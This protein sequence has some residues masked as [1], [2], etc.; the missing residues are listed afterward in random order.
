[1]FKLGNK[2][3]TKLFVWIGEIAENKFYLKRTLIYARI[4][5]ILLKRSPDGGCIVVLC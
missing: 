5:S 3:Y 1:M 2:K 4:Y